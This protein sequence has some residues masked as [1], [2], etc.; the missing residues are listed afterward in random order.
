[1]L[2]ATLEP[3]DPM[4]SPWWFHQAIVC[5]TFLKPQLFQGVRITWSFL[6]GV[7]QFELGFLLLATKAF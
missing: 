1:M 7:N 5:G 4:Q 6:E 3:W 2:T